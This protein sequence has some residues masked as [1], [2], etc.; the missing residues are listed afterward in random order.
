P[1]IVTEETRAEMKKILHEI[2][3]GQ[4][5]KEWILEN[6]AN[7]PVFS[8]LRRQDRNHP[9]EQVGKRLRSLMTWIDAKDK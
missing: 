6:K 1:R 7:R 8:A 9:V 5:A 2:Q 3:S 4:F